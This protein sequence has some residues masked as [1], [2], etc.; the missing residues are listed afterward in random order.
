MRFANMNFEQIWYPNDFV[1][2]ATGTKIDAAGWMALDWF[3]QVSNATSSI[4]TLYPD[5]Y[6]LDENEICWA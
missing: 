3:E 5:K 6:R 4:A 2:A 1:C